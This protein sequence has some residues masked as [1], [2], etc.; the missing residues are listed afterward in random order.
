[1]NAKPKCEI[2]EY[3]GL[4]YGRK[5]FSFIFKKKEI[6]SF[7]AKWVEKYD[8]L[9]KC[10]K[11]EV[12]PL[13]MKQ[14]LRLMH[15]IT[16]ALRLLRL[17]NISDAYLNINSKNTIIRAHTISPGVREI[18]HIHMPVPKGA[19]LKPQ[20]KPLLTRLPPRHI[21]RE[22]TQRYICSRGQPNLPSRETTQAPR[23]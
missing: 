5:Y 15:Y 23:C 4:S 14:D 16:P 2:N 22:W 17:T 12:S 19:G 7:L 9:V 21:S 3:Q 18:N 13:T 10:N 8:F 20:E 1:L 6:L 11:N